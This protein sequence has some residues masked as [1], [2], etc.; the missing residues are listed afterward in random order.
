MALWRLLARVVGA[1]MGRF[2]V[3]RAWRA[4]LRLILERVFAAIACGVGRLKDDVVVEM[5]SGSPEEFWR[6]KIL[7]GSYFWQRTTKLG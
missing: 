2:I 4:P 7:S 6:I 3:L 5:V 1:L